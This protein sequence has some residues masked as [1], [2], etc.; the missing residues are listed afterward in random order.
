[1]CWSRTAPS[2]MS[3]R[4]QTP[5]TGRWCLQPSGRITRRRL[6]EL[7]QLQN[8]KTIDRIRDVLRVRLTTRPEGCLENMNVPTDEQ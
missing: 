8:K 2:G 1:M 4:G 7:P 3:S 6:S 5:D